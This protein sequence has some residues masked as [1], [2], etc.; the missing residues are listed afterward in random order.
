MCRGAIYKGLD[1]SGRA[2][3]DIGNR[4]GDRQRDVRDRDIRDD[5]NPCGAAIIT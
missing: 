1:D 4:N 3:G 5:D 2:V